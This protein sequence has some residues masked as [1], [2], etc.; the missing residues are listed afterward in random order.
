MNRSFHISAL[1]ASL[2][3]GSIMPQVLSAD[4]EE[5]HYLAFASDYHET[6]DSIETAFAGMPGSETSSIDGKVEYVSLIGDMVGEKGGEHPEYFSSGILDTVREVL[7]QMQ[8]ENTSIIWADHDMSVRDDAGIVKGMDGYQSGPIF[9]GEKKD[10]TPAYYVYCIGFY[11]MLDGG[12]KSREAAAEFKEWV[13]KVDRSVPIIVLCHAPI[14]AKRGDNLGAMYWNE[15]LNYAATGIEGIVTTGTDALIIRNIFFLHGHNHTND[16]NEYFFQAGATMDVQ[17]DT[18]LLSSDQDTES[19]LVFDEEYYEKYY[20]TYNGEDVSAE[21]YELAFAKA[22]GVESDIY[23]HS[24]TAGYLKTSGNATLLAIREDTITLT[25]M[26]NGENVDVGVDADLQPVGK[27]I[28]IENFRKNIRKVHSSLSLSKKNDAGE[29]LNGAMFLLSDDAG[30][31]V[32]FEGGSFVISS[33][34][35]RMEPLLPVPGKD[36]ILLLEEVQAPKGYLASEE[37]YEIPLQ[38][39][40]SF[41]ELP[42]DHVY[43]VTWTYC[44]DDME[45]NELVIINQKKDPVTIQILIDGSGYLNIDGTIYGTASI[46]AEADSSLILN[47]AAAEGYKLSSVSLNGI[48]IFSSFGRDYLLLCDGNKEIILTFIRKDSS[49]H[50]PVTGIE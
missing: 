49:Y 40:E 1:I 6:K 9:M 2:L 8:K 7:P 47:A 37:R 44:F 24:L 32:L 39:K 45:E 4:E 34:D 30:N 12:E 36:R 48:N 5:V 33:E 26:N 23:Y 3:I 42:K 50:I 16:K 19:H 29:L 11:H 25:K 17:I 41:S 20:G 18:T 22:T 21:E 43:D 15:A 13:D 27:M 31:E 46:T 14:Q 35:E 38:V 28:E 10:G